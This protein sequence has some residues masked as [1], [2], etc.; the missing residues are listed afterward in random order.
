MPRESQMLR[1]YFL[2]PLNYSQ[3]CVYFLLP[4]SYSPSCV[5][6]LWRHGT[7]TEINVPFISFI[8]S[9]L[10]NAFL[11]SFRRIQFTLLS[12]NFR[13]ICKSIKE[14]DFHVY[15]LVCHVQ[16]SYCTLRE[17][18]H[19]RPTDLFFRLNTL[20]THLSGS[21]LWY[22]NELPLSWVIMQKFLFVFCTKNFALPVST[23]VYKILYQAVNAGSAV[24]NCTRQ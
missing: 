11:K 16:D 14:R 8:F 5:Y 4:L 2:L 21:N 7:F 3:S 10:E 17:K 24:Y 23:A 12:K 19:D 15:L 22:L 6:F 1:V 9:T 20:C 18:P 13:R